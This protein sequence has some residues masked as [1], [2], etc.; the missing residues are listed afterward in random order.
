MIRFVLR[1]FNFLRSDVDLVHGI[2]NVILLEMHIHFGELLK[3][4]VVVSCFQLH[5]KHFKRLSLQILFQFTHKIR[6]FVAV[7]F[8]NVDEIFMEVVVFIQLLL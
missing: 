5:L 6:R 1:L 3:T 4:Y 8:A 2:L 7:I